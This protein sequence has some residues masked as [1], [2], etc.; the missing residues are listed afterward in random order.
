MSLG[1]HKIE[2]QQGSRRKSKRLGRGNA[3]GKGTYAAKG[4]KGQ[5][6]RSGGR[7]GLQRLGFKQTLQAVPKLPGFRSLR[8]KAQT[9][10]LGRLNGAFADGET[11]T[12]EY[13]A[14]KHLVRTAKHPVKIVSKGSLEKK[15]VISGCAASASAQAA[16]E[17]VGGQVVSAS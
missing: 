14:Q 10:T 13:L 15:L 3:S 8:P 16:I 5:R 11:V 2:P 12:P 17:K 1:A 9:V 6:A 7:S 4:M